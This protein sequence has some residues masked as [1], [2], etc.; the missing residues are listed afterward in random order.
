MSDIQANTE[1]PKA[2]SIRGSVVSIRLESKYGRKLI[3]PA[4]KNAEAF[5]TLC[6]AKTFS[7]EQVQAIEDLGFKIEVKTDTNWKV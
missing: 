7:K 3:Y 2:K 5:A 6:G 1:T 4:D